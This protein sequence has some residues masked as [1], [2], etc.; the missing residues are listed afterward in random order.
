MAGRTV[1][2]FIQ[3]LRYALRLIAKA[4]LFSCYVMLPLALGIGL[5]GAIFLLTDALLLRPLPLKN[6]ETLVRIA[7][8]IQNI[9]IRSYY[10]YDDMA[11]LRKRST[12]FSEV[13]GYADW[14][15][16][17][18]D[19][20]G[21]TRVR[22]QMVTGNFFSALG[23][24]PLYGR[25]LGPSDEFQPAASP[26]AVL[27]Y[28]YWRRAF[29]G[30]PSVVGKILQLD[31][32]P[33]TI[34]GV[35]PR[36]FNG[37]E[38]ETTPDL[39]LPLIAGDLL[40]GG[41]KSES[42]RQ[43]LYSLAAR[44]RPGITLESARAET[45][46]IVDAVDQRK[47]T[48]NERILVQPLAMGVSLLRPRFGTA[49]TLLMCGVGLLLLIVCA[50]VGGLLLARV[51]ARRE[52]IAVRLA[53]GASAG[54]VV[55]QCLTESFVLAAI[56]TIAGSAVAISAIPLLTRSLPVLR[57]AGA[58]LL[59]IAL[60]VRPDW[61]FYTFA[62]LLCA[63]CAV[64]AGV[65]AAFEAN[66]ANLNASLR[67]ARASAHVPLRWALVALEISLCTFL[68]GAAGSLISTF[69]HLR[70]ID[71]GFD[72][73]HVIAFSVDPAMARY[74][75]QQTADLETRLLTKVRELA[76][77]QSAGIATI[78]LMHG[79]GMKTT[80]APAGEITPRSD[81]MNTSL[82]F[83]S[84][85]Y[86]ETLGIPFLAGDNFRPDEHTSKPERVIVNRAFVRR[87]FTAGDPIGRKF[88]V[89]SD[90]IVQGD[91]EIIGVV[92]D[93]KYRSLREPIPPTVYHFLPRDSKRVDP[94]IL[95]VRTQDRPERLIPSVQRALQAIDPRLPF[96]EIHTLA[97]EVDSTVW[98]ERLLAWLSS[99]F[100]F[101]A[102]ALAALG[103]YATLAYAITQS[104]GEIGIRVALGARAGH[105]VR[106]FSVR[107]VGVAGIGVTAGIGALYAAVPAFRSVL[108][109]VSASDP[110]M[111]AAAAAGVLLIAL[112]ATVV[113][114]SQALRVDPAVVLR[115]Q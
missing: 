7:Q 42:S 31:E 3:D 92:G 29:G 97:E 110:A 64:L 14:N 22:V 107:P 61:R 52:E 63:V 54:R 24:P 115:E 74:T 23:V 57:D 50:N 101:G 20:S 46:A 2:G 111:L 58:N 114:V 94:F 113:A 103:V 56:G 28:A 48:R 34:V 26:P 83:V 109:D 93:A 55:R 102:A 21:A 89:G 68:L 38:V 53:L 60:D 79:T 32:R 18:R 108:Y 106:L 66:R 16:A 45:E 4:P 91:Q 39:R 71:P 75:P 105:V 19:N 96:Y 62:F 80:V 86:F 17:A 73:D 43:L 51:S 36:W 49:L 78:G 99:I 40:A 95:H 12:G 9:G 27:S 13:F 77:V 6:P 35:M 41:P 72:R 37:V 59:T 11:A 33:F 87:F 88:G 85:E 8:N 69:Q 100:A 84:P 81:F 44:I 30:D 25:V 47:L 10:S 82:N 1:S 5:N 90:V 70:S 67:A 104:R 15:G 98:G 112:V 65:P 76:G